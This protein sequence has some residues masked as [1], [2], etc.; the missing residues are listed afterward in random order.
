MTLLRSDG[1]AGRGHLSPSPAYGP[2][3][4]PDVM[5]ARNGNAGRMAGGA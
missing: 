1:G 2:R 3:V 4:S 5:E